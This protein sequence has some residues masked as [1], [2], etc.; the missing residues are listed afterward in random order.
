MFGLLG[1]KLRFCGVNPFNPFSVSGK[2]WY[3]KHFNARL[4]EYD[5]A[6]REKLNRANALLS[7]ELD[8][9]F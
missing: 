9:R 3:E 6:R 8:G 4:D 2:T 7:R 5:V 1:M